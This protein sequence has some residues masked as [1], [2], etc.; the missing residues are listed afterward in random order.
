M[1]TKS[2]DER[3]IALERKITPRMPGTTIGRVLTDLTVVDRDCIEIPLRARCHADGTER[4]V[5]FLWCLGIGQMDEPKRF[6]YGY[7]VEDA[8]C[9]AESWANSAFVSIWLNFNAIVSMRLPCSD[10]A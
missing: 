6:F 7:R 4:E 3:V 2:F 9:A 1:A 5:V 10:L 8:L